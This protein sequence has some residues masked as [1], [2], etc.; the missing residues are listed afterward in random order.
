VDA[1]DLDLRAR[2][3]TGCIPPHLVSR[4]VE[5][6]HCEEVEFQA[7]RGEWFCAREWASSGSKSVWYSDG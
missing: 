4:L 1:A 7:G 2:T 6:G 3:L 5:L